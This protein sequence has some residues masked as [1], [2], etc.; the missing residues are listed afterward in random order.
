VKQAKQH[1]RGILRSVTLTLATVL[2]LAG[3]LTVTA[4]AASATVFEGSSTDPAGDG[5]SA[6]RD[7]TSAAV[8]YDD[9]AGTISF[10]MN[11]AAAHTN[12]PVQ[13]VGGIGTLNPSGGCS[14]PLA[15][16]GAIRPDGAVRWVRGNTSANPAEAAGDAQIAIDGPK[17]TLSADADELRGMTP[18]CGEALLS[19]PADPNQTHDTTNAFTVAPRPTGPKL[20]VEI[21]GLGATI[22]R[23]AEAKVKVKVVNGGDGLAATAKVSL[24]AKGGTLKPGNRSLGTIP[25]GKS[26]V[27]VF[28]LKVGKRSKGTITLRAKATARGAKAVTAGKSIKIKAPGKKPKPPKPGGRGGLVGQLFWGFEEYQY[29]RSSDIL[30]LY[31][32]N[33]KFVHWG[34]PKGGL[35]NC[36]KVTAKLDEDGE[37]QPGCLRYTYNP[38]S[39]K[40]SIGKAKGTFRG[41]NLKLK[42]DQD[43]WRIDGKTWFTSAFA[44]PG[45]RF[46]LTLINRTYFGLCGI[47]PYCTNSQDL[48]TLD[49]DGRFGRTASSLTTGGGGSIPFIAIGSYPPE[50]RGTYTVLGNGRIRFSFDNGEVKTETLVIQTNK[51]GK[52]DAAGE[53]I[54]LDDAYYYKEE[55]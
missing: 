11:L 43:M 34:I 10:T 49:R 45:A 55:D 23:G 28:N 38:K 12:S 25:P 1:R 22:K 32:S 14:Y 6:D 36:R 17:I 15:V 39:G 42:M 3:G 27:G 16:V 2:A 44:K 8:A 30:G 31:F 35:V 29:D 41:G 53:G 13:I 5:S 51:R 54:L 26:S 40:L 37:L 20:G 50:D 46:K 24:S 7:L 4:S 21:S 47:T 18:N 52:P 9:T 48:V 33:S 19:N